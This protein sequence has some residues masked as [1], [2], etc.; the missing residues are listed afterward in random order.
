MVASMKRFAAMAFLLCGCLR[1]AVRCRE[2]NG[3]V[4]TRIDAKGHVATLRERKP[5]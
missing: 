2:E 3:T 4:L 5:H 1:D